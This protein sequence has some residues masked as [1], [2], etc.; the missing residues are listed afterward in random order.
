MF[1]Q[2]P[3]SFFCP[4]KI[5]KW[6]CSYGPPCVHVIGGVV[7]CTNEPSPEGGLFS[8]S[9]PCVRRC[10]HDQSDQPD[11]SPAPSWARTRQRRISLFDKGGQSEAAKSN[12]GSVVGT[13][14]ED[15]TVPGVGSPTS[16]ASWT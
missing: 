4:M 5:W 14:P 12:A 8:V 6:V 10:H 15:H 16:V 11:H 2:K 9:A 1:S 13:S 3:S 7:S